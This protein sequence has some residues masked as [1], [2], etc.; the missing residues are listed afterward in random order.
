MP[1]NADVECLQ[2]NAVNP[3]PH[4]R[5]RGPNN[6]EAKPRQPNN[7]T[8]YKKRANINIATLNMNGTTTPSQNMDIT[9]K[10]S[11]INHTIRKHKITILAL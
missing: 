3:D 11:M 7:N 1:T 2:Q 6:G 10:W 4:H 9:E 8:I 5:N